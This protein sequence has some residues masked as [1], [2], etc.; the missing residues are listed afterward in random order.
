MR[1]AI[2]LAAVSIVFAGSVSA[3]ELPKALVDAY[4]NVQT[5]L[6]ADKLDGIAAQ[7]S[8]IEAATAALGPDAEKLAGAAKK[9]Q[10]AKDMAAA[11][12]AF[13]DVSEALIAYAEKTKSEFGADVQVAFCPM[14]NKPWL[15]REKEI[16]N[17][18]YGASMI[19]CGSF[20]K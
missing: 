11:R 3:V 5:A 17:P 14:A 10:A 19:S 9:L 7:A 4:L 20:K 15:Q 6:S 8:V 2:T 1:L 18:Y 16:R 13:G 12:A